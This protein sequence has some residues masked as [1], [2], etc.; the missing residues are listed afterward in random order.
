MKIVFALG[1]VASLSSCGSFDR[2]TANVTGSSESCIGG[3]TYIQFTSG[4]S[5]KYN[6]EGKVVT[7]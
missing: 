7:C 5:V 1:L 3:V 4:V 2:V 6:H